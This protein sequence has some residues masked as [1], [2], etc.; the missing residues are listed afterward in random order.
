MKLRYSNLLLLIFIEFIINLSL[1]SQEAVY[2]STKGNDSNS[3]S[4]SSPF[5]SIKAAQAAL[6][7]SKNTSKP[8]SIIYLRGGKYFISNTIEWNEYDSGTKEFPTYI[9]AYKNEEVR[10]SGGVQFH[11]NVLQKLKNKEILNRINSITARD[12]IYCFDL[13]KAGLKDLGRLKPKGFGHPVL[14]SAMELFFDDQPMKLA[15]YPNQDYSYIKIT[16]VQDTGS[17]PR[18]GDSTNRGGIFRCNDSRI[19]TWLNQDQIWIQGMFGTVW[20]DDFLNIESIDTNTLSIKVKQAHLYGIKGGH[21]KAINVLEELDQPGEYMI[22]YLNGMLYLY[23]PQKISNQ[24]FMLSMMEAP[25]FTIENTAHI[26]IEKILFESTRGIGIYMEGGHDNIIQGCTFRNMGNLAVSIGLGIEPVYRY[27]S[28]LKAKP[29]KGIIGSLREYE[30][31]YNSFNRNAGFNNGV[32]SCDIYNIGAGGISLGGGDRKTLEAGNNFVDNC[33]IYSTNRLELTY[34]PCVDITGVGNRVTHCEMHDATHSAILF[35]GNDHLIEYNIF[36]HNLKASNDAGVIY[37]GRD[38]TSYGTIIQNNFF[39][40]NVPDTTYFPKPWSQGIYIDDGAAGITVSKNIFANMKTSILASGWDTKIHNNLAVNCGSVIIFQFRYRFP[41]MKQRCLD[42]NVM[43]PPFSI[44]YP[45]LPIH[46]TLHDTA[47]FCH[48]SEITNNVIVGKAKL[49]YGFDTK[50]KDIFILKDNC[51]LSGNP[52]F[53]NEEKMDF[54]LLPDSEIYK[55]V[56][57]FENIPQEKMGLS[58]DSFRMNLDKNK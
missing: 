55:Y 46:L 40:N 50:P 31:A 15:Q 35:N 23:P 54:H 3:G 42:V 37:T 5:L 17:V 30:Y 52:G 11:A 43:N 27:G 36:H 26:R 22:D 53:V 51:K 4:I 58:K 2:V 45:S 6:R 18:Y 47:G 12:S 39:Y 9:K 33:H 16:Q 21:F 14:P 32:Q 34:R 48:G 20:A 25:I 24:Y 56:P 49:C 41:I 29:Q 8:I 57:T 13:F 28:E 7:K 1:F 44:K 19:K 10:I 38:L